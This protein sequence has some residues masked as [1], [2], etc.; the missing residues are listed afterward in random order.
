MM[1]DGG[2]FRQ[3]STS[4]LPMPENQQ[5][6][7]P[8]LKHCEVTGKKVGEH[9]AFTD[10]DLH[11]KLKLRRAISE[12]LTLE[13]AEQQLAFEESQLEDFDLQ[14]KLTMR[15]EISEGSQHATQ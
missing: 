8:S 2:P 15:R 4:T 5:E 6:Q 1:L 13:E 7:W 3:D 14:R 10:P 12:G 9:L 11:K